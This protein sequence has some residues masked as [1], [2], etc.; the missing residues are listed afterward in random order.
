MHLIWTR[1]III[2]LLAL[3]I[4]AV[5]LVLIGIGGVMSLVSRGPLELPQLK[6]FIEQRINDEL[7]DETLK[8]GA[9]SLTS[10]QDGAANQVV[11][12]NVTLFGSTHEKLLTVPE[13]RTEFSLMNLLR[14]TVSPSQ[15]EII[16]TQLK[17]IRQRDGSIA[18]L[19]LTDAG[20]TVFKGDILKEL[21]RFLQRDELKNLTSIALRKADIQLTDVRTG[22]QWE[23]SDSLLQFTRKEDQITLHTQ[24][25]VEK[26]GEDPTSLTA[27]ATHKIGDLDA[28]ILLK[29]SNAAP[30]DLA[31]MVG[32][33][34][35]MRILDA[36]VSGSLTARLGNDGSVGDLHGVLDLGQ[37]RVRQTPASQPIGFDQAKVYFSYDKASDRLEFS[38]IT[39]DTTSGTVSSEGY[40]VLERSDTG[41]VRSMAGQFRFD[42][43]L[44]NRPDVFANPLKLNGAG[45]D[46]RLSFNPLKIEVG[47][48]TVFDGDATYRLSG[49]SKAGADFWTNQYDIE[50][51][52][53]HRDR[54]MAFW[55]IK[56][57][58][59][60]RKW[61]IENITEGVVRNFRGGLRSKAG[62]FKYA[63]N[64]DVSDARVRFMKTM[65][66][67]RDGQGYGYLTNNDLRIDL[68]AGHLIAAD[69]TVVDGA[70]SSFYIPNINTRPAIG[71]IT[72]S[73]RGG[74]QAAL[75]LLDVEKFQFLK[76]V[77]LTPQVA[78]GTVSVTGTLQVPLTKHAKPTD[79]VFDAVAE[80]RDLTSDTLIK[81][82]SLYG[83]K[84]HFA[85]TDKG[86]EM[87]GPVTLDGVP[88][89]ARWRLG[90]G[91][92]AAKGSEV[93][94]DVGLTQKNLDALGITLPKGSIAGE[95]PAKVVVNIKKGKVPT[96]TV[97]SNL[98]GAKLQIPALQWIKSSKST[99][100]LSL[101]GSFGTAPTV[102]TL[103]LT[104]PGMKAA[105]KIDFNKDGTMKTLRLSH[106]RAGDWLDSAALIEMGGNGN[107]HI[108]LSGGAADMRNFNISNG[109]GNSDA[110]GS[111]PIDVKLD[112]LTIVTG[113][114]LTNFKAKLEPG[115]GMSGTFTGRVNGGSSIS[116]TLFP[117]KYGTAFDLHATDA[118]R[119]LASADLMENVYGGDMR[120]VILPSIKGG[121]YDGN[122]KVKNT[123]MT[124]T[125]ALAGLMNGISIVGALQQLEGNGIHFS[126]VEGK[127]LL[128]PN[129]VQI[130]DISAVGPSI[131]LTL[132]GWY[133]S[134]N[135]TVDFEG[136]TTPLYAVNGLFQKALGKLGGRKKGEG[137]FSF[138][139]RM[140]GPAD[141]PKVSVNP[142]SILTPGAFREIFRKKRP[143]SKNKGQVTA[144]NG[145]HLNSKVLPTK[146]KTKRVK[147]KRKKQPFSS[148]DANDMR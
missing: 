56:A 110:T 21:D 53:A 30:L 41:G 106:L 10:G 144:G 99:G 127:F 102:D 86:L 100:K 134:Q 33:L 64:F 142:L 50:V 9:I 121:E 116:G 16:G 129:G 29:F 59:K 98:V 23:V 49:E 25:S 5:V 22:H 48:L 81:G 137:L 52:S 34:D 65:P 148:T 74:L 44:L 89:Q 109:T 128:R 112:R 125:S 45:L 11:L 93:V 3:T 90:F 101:S 12:S 92:A 139:Y 85:A 26:S 107:A 19:R 72:L 87:Q 67:L 27:T 120:V 94:A 51:S 131:G 108:T 136:V 61:L 133:N 37:G 91:K 69:N 88:M 122:L 114:A 63:F 54:I 40:A 132:D 36:R 96:Y 113:I 47:S 75:H 97:N 123:R 7:A 32:A 83:A 118:G 95:A 24:I 145:P 42:D 103:S 73:A 15:I 43:L 79:V 80:V 143:T 126:T 55:P 31:D 8:I 140:K 124:S 147:Q 2:A 105:G 28:G 20:D 117:H 138:T 17:L 77:G 66:E 68:T 82:H 13:I 39:L 6:S 35:W 62:K 38:Q 1:Q 130:K 71:D 4:G 14:G 84:M 57:I 60:T 141:D 119:V 70:G 104:A 76:K 18:F 146:Q 58:P 78:S 46:F 135:R 111:S 115:K